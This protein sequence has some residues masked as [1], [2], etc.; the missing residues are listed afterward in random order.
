MPS[1]EECGKAGRSVP[2]TGLQHP[3]CHCSNPTEHARARH[4]AADPHDGGPLALCMGCA[5]DDYS[6]CMRCGRWVPVG[7][8]H[9]DDNDSPLC[10]RCLKGTTVPVKISP[11]MMKALQYVVDYATE[12]SGADAGQMHT[13]SVV[14]LRERGLIR[15][16]QVGSYTRERQHGRGQ[17]RYVSTEHNVPTIRAWLTDAGRALIDGRR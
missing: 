16:E 2:A 3:D 1:C 6:Y 7:I 15:V 13:A 8:L 10:P 11:A 17:S 9:L 12:R 5:N 14:A 4:P